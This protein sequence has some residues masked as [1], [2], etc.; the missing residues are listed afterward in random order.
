MAITLQKLQ[1]Q[2]TLVFGEDHDPR[3]HMDD[4]INDAGRYLCNMHSWKW[5]QRPPVALNFVAG[6]PWVSLPM[7]FGFGEID[8]IAMKDQV[9]YGS[10]LTSLS[11]LEYMRS[12]TIL[13]PSF[14][15]FALVHPTQ[16]SQQEEAPT[17]RLEVYPSPISDDDDAV[18]LNYRA[19]WVPLADADAAA[20]IPPSIDRLL[21][22]LV[23][24][25][26]QIEK[27]GNDRALEG[28]EK[29][30]FLDRLKG[31]D[32]AQ[33]RNLGP[34]EGGVLQRDRNASSNW[35]YT[36]TGVPT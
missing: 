33:Q 13:S 23:R 30:E 36:H 21:A 9:T 3:I 28:I 2:A 12:T 26:A 4:V 32:G 5:R 34:T 8:G 7:D 6:Q 18:S 20:N 19:G 35:N 27:D 29:S 24:S 31:A 16:P 11:S 14:Y 15:Y 22:R 17:P 10:E 25:F 1:D